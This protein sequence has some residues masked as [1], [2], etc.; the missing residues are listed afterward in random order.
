MPSRKKFVVPPSQP[1]M[2]QYSRKANKKRE[3]EDKALKLSIDSRINELLMK[4]K[5]AIEKDQDTS[6]IRQ[7]L[8]STYA[9]QQQVNQIENEEASASDNSL[10]SSSE[11]EEE[12]LSQILLTP[13]SSTTNTMNNKKIKE[14]ARLVNI[15]NQRKASAQA[16]VQRRKKQYDDDDNDDDEDELT[17]T[18]NNNNNIQTSDTMTDAQYKKYLLFLQDENEKHSNSDYNYNKN[19]PITIGGDDISKPSSKSNPYPHLFRFHRGQLDKQKLELERFSKEKNEKNQNK[20]ASAT[21]TSTS[22]STS[23]ARANSRVLTRTIPTTTTTTT[24]TTTATAS[25][26]AKNKHFNNAN[27]ATMLKL[28]SVMKPTS[29]SDWDQLFDE[30]VKDHPDYMYSKSGPKLHKKFNQLVQ[31]TPPSGNPDKAKIITA[32]QQIAMHIAADADGV[33]E[34][35]G[36]EDEAY[37]TRDAIEERRNSTNPGATP[38]DAIDEDEEVDNHNINHHQPTTSTDDT[39]LLPALSGLDDLISVNPS[40]SM[41]PNKITGFLSEKSRKVRQFEETGNSVNNLVSLAAMGMFMKFDPSSKKEEQEKLLKLEQKMEEREEKKRK[42][43]AKRE[44]RRLELLL[45]QQERETAMEE[46]RMK[47]LNDQEE[48]RERREEQHQMM[49]MAMMQSFRSPPPPSYNPTSTQ[50]SPT[51][52]TPSTPTSS[53]PYNSMTRTPTSSLPSRQNK[54]PNSIDLTSTTSGSRRPISK[55]PLP[56]TA[57]PKFCGGST[58]I[59]ECPEN[60][61]QS[62]SSQISTDANSNVSRSSAGGHSSSSGNSAPILFEFDRPNDEQQDENGGTQ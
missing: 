49:M 31:E 21:S 30:W 29:S 43:K 5:E 48:R 25:A 27:L 36:E 50:F 11:E 56:T 6:S 3:E 20:K 13:P 32:A 53:M 18:Y 47:M 34:N 33:T 45:K 38:D 46:K 51:G 42:D 26:S 60:H 9:H 37:L 62:P 41:D 61:K 1:T 52:W 59:E 10:S 19:H 44:E 39:P 23:T 35:E 15:D 12:N 17:T 24:T 4:E 14:R 55:K 58:D 16:A 40:P 54:S 7:E 57:K 22:T 2:T 28:A 8:E